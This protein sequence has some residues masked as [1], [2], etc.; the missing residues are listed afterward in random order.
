MHDEPESIVQ[1]AELLTPRV[2]RLR[3]WSEF[4]ASSVVEQRQRAKF[5]SNTNT[6]LICAAVRASFQRL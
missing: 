4:S 5:C 6:A 3:P 2:T 1:S